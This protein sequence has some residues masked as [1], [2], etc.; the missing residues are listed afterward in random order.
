MIEIF[1]R[2][3]FI[4]LIYILVNYCFMLFAYRKW[5][6]LGIMMF[7][8]LSIVIANIQ[9]NKLIV[10]FGVE[11]T[12]G[13]IAYG[14]IFLIE[15]ILS[16][17]YGKKYAKTVVAI[18]FL[19][20]VFT[21]IVMNLAILISP[22]EADTA[23]NAIKALFSPLLRLTVASLMAYTISTYLDIH[24][25]QLIRKIFPSFKNIWIRNNLSTIISQIVD[26]V[27]FTLVAFV[28]IYDTNILISI[29]FSTYFLKLIISIADTPFV[30]IA[31][32][33]KKKGIIKE[34]DDKI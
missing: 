15:D 21:T 32:W 20:M 22:S 31:A 13:N 5:G 27:I 6:K 3:E 18:G 17:N 7:I 4:W 14:G 25:Y 30:Y 1:G 10:L 26:S 24:L 2:N 8:P 34:V 12:M 29:M 11:A 16:E 9:V 33:W 28:G 19:T 23:Q